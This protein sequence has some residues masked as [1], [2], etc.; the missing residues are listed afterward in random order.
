MRLC[1]RS[2]LEKGEEKALARRL[3]GFT[4]REIAVSCTPRRA[5]RLRPRAG[6]GPAH[7]VR[8]MSK[9]RRVSA[10]QSHITTFLWDCKHFLCFSADFVLERLLGQSIP[11]YAE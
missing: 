7:E 3:A 5:V 1:A 8:K 10:A 2:P 9:N 6:F 4:A 11:G